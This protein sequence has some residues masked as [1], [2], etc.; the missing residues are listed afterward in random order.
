MLKQIFILFMF[1]IGSAHAEGLSALSSLAPVNIESMNFPKPPVVQDVKLMEEQKLKFE[2][3]E[4]QKKE[5]AE[6][7]A[8]EAE[9]KNPQPLVVIINNQPQPEPENPIISAL[10]FGAGIAT[11]G[12]LRF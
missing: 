12:L 8:I 6:N 3:F 11:R 2:L 9:A 10:K 1:A 4:Y 7:E 5:V